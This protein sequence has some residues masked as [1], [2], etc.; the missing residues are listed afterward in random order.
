MTVGRK[1][2][3]KGRGK[4]RKTEREAKRTYSELRSKGQRKKRGRCTQ[5]QTEISIERR[6]HYKR[7]EDKKQRER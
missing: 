3:E 7:Q 6:R 2:C 5:S 1:S 4:D